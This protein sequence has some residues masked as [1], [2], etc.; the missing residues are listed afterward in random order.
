MRIMNERNF[1][2]SLSQSLCLSGLCGGSFIEER[3]TDRR[4]ILHKDSNE[5]ISSK[6]RFSGGRGKRIGGWMRGARSRA[7]AHR[8]IVRERR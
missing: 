6:L 1:S 3:E 4:T 7:S 2:L 8:P 5:G